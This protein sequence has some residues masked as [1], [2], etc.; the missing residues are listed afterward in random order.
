MIC[1]RLH[2]FNAVNT[3]V[4]L[5][6]INAIFICI[7]FDIANDTTALYFIMCMPAVLNEAGIVS[8]ASVCMSSVS[9]C[10]C[11]DSKQL[12]IGS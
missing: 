11:K 3:A 7:V 1:V 6:F 5:I 8:V 9:V 4:L 12:L 2:H 10:P